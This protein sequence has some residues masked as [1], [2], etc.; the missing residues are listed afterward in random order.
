MASKKCYNVA[1]CI[2]YVIHFYVHF[3]RHLSDLILARLPTESRNT[4]CG[5]QWYHYYDTLS[6]LSSSYVIVVLWF[7]LD[8]VSNSSIKRIF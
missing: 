3:R 4:Y 1:S 8:K 7:V 6:I 5:V 2:D